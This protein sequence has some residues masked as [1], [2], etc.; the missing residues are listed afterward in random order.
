MTTWAECL[1]RCPICKATGERT[2]DGKS[3]FCHGSRRHCFDF[4]RSG[5]LNFSRDGKT[6]DA[7][8]AV[9]ARSAFLS[10]G[11]YRPLSDRVCEILEEIGAK[12]VLDAGCGEGYYTNRMAASGRTV[13][14]VDLSRDGIDHAAKEAKRLGF[15]AGF[16]VCSLF[17]LPIADGALDAVT[18]LFAPCAETEFARV[19]KNG[20]KLLVVGAGEEHLMGLKQVLYDLPRPNP[21]RCDLPTALHLSR[22]ERLRFEITV[23]GADMVDAL[24]SMTPYY[25]R[26][27]E[28][29]RAKLHG[30][31]QLE[32]VCDFD[33]FLYERT[34][35]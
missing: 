34:V 30:L 25:W 10:A 5:Y 26:T 24:F 12:T 7:K 4:S 29:D 14:G 22:R 6:G 9:N 32:T 20:G 21:G 1:L 28:R 35:E 2:A 11:Y 27:S 16:A 17:E 13:L 19:L 3:F 31:Q 8:T 15:G 33:L 18:N 23:E